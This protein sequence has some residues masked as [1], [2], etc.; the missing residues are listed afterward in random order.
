[1]IILLFPVLALTK[2]LDKTLLEVGRRGGRHGC[3]G[4]PGSRH[5]PKRR[6]LEWGYYI[7]D[8]DTLICDSP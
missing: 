2:T 6:R 1:M 8:L 5:A 7:L 4:C 3:F